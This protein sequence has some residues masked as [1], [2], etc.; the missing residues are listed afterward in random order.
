[1]IQNKNGNYFLLKIIINT[2]M[3]LQQKN[4]K[5]THKQHYVFLFVC[6]M[7]DVYD[8]YDVFVIFI[9]LV[10]LFCCNIYARGLGLMQLKIVAYFRKM[11]GLRGKTVGK[12][13]FSRKKGVWG[14]TPTKIGVLRIGVPFLRKFFLVVESFQSLHL[15]IIFIT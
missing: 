9:L 4:V 5:P 12:A 1:M 14:W 6:C 10:I 15:A 3:E 2:N 8:A 13:V 7:Y 11:R